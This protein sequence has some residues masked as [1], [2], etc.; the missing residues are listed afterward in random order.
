[1][2]VGRSFVVS[3]FIA[4][5]S[6]AAV[7]S[8]LVRVMHNKHVKEYSRMIL[9]MYVLASITSTGWLADSISY[10]SSHVASKVQ[11]H[12][13]AYNIRWHFSNS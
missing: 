1:M 9:M 3:V 11:Y 7:N 5:S 10:L 2:L 13:G 8:S 6:P 12:T 4:V